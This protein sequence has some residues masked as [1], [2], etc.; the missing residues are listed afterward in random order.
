MTT[1]C[2]LYS[3]DKI[4]YEFQQTLYKHIKI[5]LHSHKFK[6]NEICTLISWAHDTTQRVIY[7]RSCQLVTELCTGH[8]KKKE[9]NNEEDDR[10]V[11]INANK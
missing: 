7:V 5:P 11:W 8:K 9:Q 3:F 6:K 10:I 1:P 4:N 2:V